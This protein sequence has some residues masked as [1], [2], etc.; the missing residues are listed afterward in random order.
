MLADEETSIAPAT[1]A[2][3][4]ELA[5]VMR[6]ADRLECE[7]LG[8]SPL[9]TLEDALASSSW[10]FTVR[11]HGEIAAMAGLT[12]TEHHG[13]A[14]GG[15]SSAIPWALTGAVVDRYP[16]QFWRLSKLFAALM[17]HHQ[18]NLT[19]LVDARHTSALRWLERLGFT[20]GP[21]VE[22]GPNNLPHHV[23]FTGG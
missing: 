20:I 7:A 2:D 13:S 9:A 19:N 14:L 1:R 18:P 17:R 16:M 8:V 12:P 6:A 11:F 15:R 4:F 22:M 21:V 3:C 23:V 5:Q 10:A